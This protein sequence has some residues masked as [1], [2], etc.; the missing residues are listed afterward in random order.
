MDE[1]V[2]KPTTRHPEE[3]LNQT[4]VLGKQPALTV[5]AESRVVSPSGVSGTPSGDALAGVA[6]S[7]QERSDDGT[8]SAK[9]MSDTEDLSNAGPLSEATVLFDDAVDLPPNGSPSENTPPDHVPSGSLPLHHV[10]SAQPGISAQ[11]VTQPT[12]VQ[13]GTVLASHPPSPESVKDTTCVVM[14]PGMSFDSFR[15]LERIGRGGMGEIWKARDLEGDRIVA[16]KLVPCGIQAYAEELQRV[17]EMFRR[18]HEL[19]HQNIGPIYAMKHH[20]QVGDYLV[21]KYIQGE[22][23]E[24][25]RM[26]FPAVVLTPTAVASVAAES[27]LPPSTPISN[28]HLVETPVT[29]AI[30]RVP[31]C[32]TLEILTPIA[33][34]LDYAHR[35]GILHRDIKPSNILVRVRYASEESAIHAA[36]SASLT[37]TESMLDDSSLTSTSKLV[38][39]VSCEFEPKQGTIVHSNASFP[40][41][42]EDTILDVQLIDFGLAMNLRSDLSYPSQTA[43][44]RL[45]M[46]PEQWTAEVLDARTDQYS[47]A[48]VLYE[49]LA[50]RLPF[51]GKTPSELRQHV[52]NDAPAPIPG[53]LP[54]VSSVIFRALA[55][56]HADRYTTCREFLDTLQQ[57]LQ[58]Q[59]S[60]PHPALV[61]PGYSAHV[62]TIPTTIPNTPT[63]SPATIN[64][65]P[66]LASTATLKELRQHRLWNIGIAILSILFGAWLV[67]QLRDTGS[68]PPTTESVAVYR[69]HLDTVYSVRISPDGKSFFTSSNDGNILQQDYRTGK[70]L[71][72]YTGAGRGI[73][74][75]AISPDGQTLA[76]AV[77]DGTALLWN[78][79]STEILHKLVDTSTSV[80][81]DITFS[82]D[83][84]AVLTAAGDGIV[85]LWDVS[86]GEE[87]RHFEDPE[88]DAI[89]SVACDRDGRYL[90]TGD[91]GGDVILWDYS[92]AEPIRQY[93]HHSEAVTAVAFSPNDRQL[94]GV[95]EDSLAVLWNIDSAQPIKVFKGASSDLFSVSF[96]RSGRRILAGSKDGVTLL[97]DISTNRI[98]HRFTGHEGTIWS[99]AITP[100]DQYCFTAGGDCTTRKWKM[101]P[102]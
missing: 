35:F 87:L 92:T 1:F 22:T 5:P 91:S 37:T 46:A 8:G 68:T 40:A 77:L 70:I 14:L 7:A 58:I 81:N 33:D 17:R 60:T 41:S 39:G 65:T 47:L 53:Y 72:T 42:Q 85:T 61:I 56:K 59:H 31:L 15:V 13:S 48:V 67:T 71:H 12:F 75:L 63:Q 50:G 30:H 23:L 51:T 34:A 18:V 38:P 21:M 83:G 29:Q 36:A 93:Q 69:E 89:R 57:A 64:E 73:I 4:E 11:P 26:R 79:Q 45:Y 62:P 90:L 55:K 95:S 100:D 25:Y 98:V 97:W 32:K 16:I 52:L 28:S 10:E 82:A 101:P 96:D 78:V 66:N 76:G 3:T 27:V 86:T 6:S 24:A 20:P 49:M 84:T 102:L 74:E 94:V 80:L 19:Q 54:L 9:V 88:Q 43:G 99:V 44:T 2:H